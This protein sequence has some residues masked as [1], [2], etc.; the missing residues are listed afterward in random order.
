MRGTAGGLKG[1][2]TCSR[3]AQA[4]GQIRAMSIRID[5]PDFL[6]CMN[7]PRNMLIYEIVTALAALFLKQPESG[8]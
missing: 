2:R 4:A 6:F 8:H 5:I 7:Q 1:A 3:T